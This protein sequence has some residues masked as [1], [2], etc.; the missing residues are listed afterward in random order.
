[1]VGEDVLTKGSP[2]LALMKWLMASTVSS[3]L[4]IL[5]MSND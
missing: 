2:R 4:I 5:T 1:M 3:G